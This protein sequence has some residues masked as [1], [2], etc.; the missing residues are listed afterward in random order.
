M[1]KTGLFS[2]NSIVKLEATEMVYRGKI[3]KGVVVFD[4]AVA[5]PEGAEVNV[6]SVE[7][8][9]S[10]TLADIFRD[11]IGCAN[12]LPADMAKNHDHYL[13]GTPKR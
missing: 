7:P 1:Y 4:E 8:Q 5:L 3:Q 12:D 13:Y 11:F 2:Y 10:P 9:T 6:E